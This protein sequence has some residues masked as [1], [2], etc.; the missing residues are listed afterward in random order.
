MFSLLQIPELDHIQIKDAL[1]S[2]YIHMV[3][4]IIIP[5][6]WEILND[7]IPDAAPSHCLKNFQIAAG[8]LNSEH[9]GVVFI[10][11]DVYK[12]LESV[13]YCI[14]NGTGKRFEN[15]ADEVIALIGRAQQSDGY[16]NTYYTVKEPHA[17]FSNLV[18]GH[19]LYS[20]GHLIEAAVAY[21]KATGKDKLLDVA[22]RFA[23]LICQVFGPAENQIKGYPGHQE[24]EL[25]LVKLYRLTGEKKYLACAKFFIEERGQSPSYFEAEIARRNGRVLFPEFREYNLLYSQAHLPVRQQHT[26]EGHAVRA[27][28]MYCAMADLAAEYEDQELLNICQEL[29][30]NVTQ[31]RM[32]ITG[33]IGS[34]GFFERFTTNYH[35]PNDSAYCETCASI[36]LAQFSRRM[37][38]MER[39]AS[40]FDIVEKAL[41]NTVLAGIS[42]NGDRYFYVNPLEVKPEACL[43]ATSLKHVKPERQRWFSVACCPTNISRTLASLGQYIYA[44]DE[45][46]L[47][48]N[49][50]ISSV[51]QADLFGGRAELQMEADMMASGKV[52][53]KVSIPGVMRMA[54]RIP[55]YSKTLECFVNG[56]PQQFYID[57]GYAIIENLSKDS[58]LTLQF[59]VKPR[60]MAADVRVWENAGKVA[61]MKGPFVYC[62]E[63]TDNGKNLASV[64]VNTS[65]HVAE[66]QDDTLPGGLPALLYKGKRLVYQNQNSSL[67][68]DAHFETE[69]TPIKAVPYCLWGNR[70]PGEMLVWQNALIW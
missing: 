64:L 11:T 14:Q 7:R 35:L 53:I 67:Y 40:Y 1:W 57:K 34:S 16:L 50:F 31:K 41:Y 5:Y 8:E 39:D 68:G 43:E 10:D 52:S 54:I 62:L 6:Q 13:A 47:Y 38:L 29:W 65:E 24:I 21:Y 17:R 3:A 12:W 36:G 58:T 32:Y 55:D 2:R 56:I 9:K 70:K 69:S 28:Y 4:D 22:R 30:R 45:Q 60:W 63:E 66:C 18:E 48:I 44:Y 46:T 49:M 51:F 19:E 59:D 61:L 20:A 25:A 26:A 27:M 37:G 23:D 42:V 15:M 33:G